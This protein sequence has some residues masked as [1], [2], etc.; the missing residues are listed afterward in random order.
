MKRTVWSKITIALLSF[1]LMGDMVVIPA[2]GGIYGTYYDASPFL[3]NFVLTGA[4]L[5]SVFSAFLCGFL[6]RY[7]SKKSLIIGGYILFLISGVGG[8]AM[9]N[10]YSLVTMRVIIGFTYGIVGT[11][12][13]GLIAE[14]FS[15]EK[16]RSFMMGAFNGSI[17]LSGLVMSLLSGFLAVS[18]WHNSFFVYHIAVLILLLAIVFLPKTAAEGKRESET[19][20]SGRD[21]LPLAFLPV[22]IAGLIFFSLYFIIV[23][24]ITIYLQEAQ[25]GDAS[26]AGILSALLMVGVFIM[27]M[28]FSAI[29]MRLKRT[30]IIFAYAMLTTAFLVLAFPVNIWV[31]GAMCII[32]GLSYGITVSY[33]YTY[34][35]MIVPPGARSLAMGIIT[36]VIGLG[37]FLSSYGLAFYK[38]VFHV[39][40]MASAFLYIGIT[41]AIGTVISII[42]NTWSRKNP[43]IVEGKGA[44]L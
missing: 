7:I 8:A 41:L 20:S 15:E 32:G 21:R 9:D 14:V 23:Y 40:T 29:Y 35:S 4:M 39:E 25:L 36:A 26:A 6:A 42:L 2:I 13:T 30:I 5:S 27:G 22:V 17:S 37:G 28:L 18:D 12:A 16:E 1:A 19:A 31:T 3:L 34:T 33:Y 43:P 24:F 11:A 44:E 10:I 38:A